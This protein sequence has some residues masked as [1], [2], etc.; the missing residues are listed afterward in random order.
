MCK[1]QQT[2][3]DCITSSPQAITFID[4][5]AYFADTTMPFNEE[6]YNSNAFDRSNDFAILKAK[7][8]QTCSM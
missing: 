3:A 6:K 1:Q 4:L 8:V 5:L 2:Q 7:Q